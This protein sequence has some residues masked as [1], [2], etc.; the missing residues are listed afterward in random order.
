MPRPLV[1]VLNTILFT[2]LVPGTILGYIPYRFTGG[3][4]RQMSG[5][6][7]WLG[8]VVIMIGAVIYFRC[9]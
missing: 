9:A 3:F 8:V 7:A 5:P 4:A 6:V 2:I 1:P